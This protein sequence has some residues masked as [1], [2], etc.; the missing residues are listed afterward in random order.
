MKGGGGALVPF[1]AWMIGWSSG[2]RKEK[3]TKLLED[4][5]K[6]DVSEMGGRWSWFGSMTM[7]TV[8]LAVLNLPVEGKSGKGG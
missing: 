2:Y 4:K 6:T 1:A 5:A 3:D 8:V 7:H